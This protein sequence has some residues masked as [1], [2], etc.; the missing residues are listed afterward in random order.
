[1]VYLKYWDLAAAYLK[2][3]VLNE[4]IQTF[5]NHSR[6]LDPILKVMFLMGKVFEKDDDGTIGKDITCQLLR[7]VQK[8][9]VHESQPSTESIVRNSLLNLV[10][11]QRVYP[12]IEKEARDLM[13]EHNERLKLEI[14]PQL[15]IKKDQMVYINEDSMSFLFKYNLV[16]SCL[17]TPTI[18]ESE[19]LGIEYLKGVV[20]FG[21]LHVT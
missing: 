20:S 4:I 10:Q 13:I 14:L 7:I 5:R 11:L 12:A 6:I 9:I 21:V 3:S 15:F 8:T 17:M 16:M 18:F 19:S 2:L 1:M